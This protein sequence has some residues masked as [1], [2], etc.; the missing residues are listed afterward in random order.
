MENKRRP[1]KLD[2]MVI[3]ISKCGAIGNARPCF[4]CMKQLDQAKF[5]N[6]RNVYY[7]NNTG[8][9]V[10]CKFDDLLGDD[11]YISSGYKMRM[12]LSKNNFV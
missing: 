2:L 5:V 12:G 6:I 11:T 1:L 3:R 4:H 9:I 10:C 7:S 8:N